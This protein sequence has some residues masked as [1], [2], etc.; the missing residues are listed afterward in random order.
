MNKQPNK[1]Y[2]GIGSRA[3]PLF[4][5]YQ[6]SLLSAI[7]EKKGYI[8]RSGCAAGADAAFEDSLELSNQLPEIY[9][10]NANFPKKVGGTN[11]P[12]YICPMDR[13]G[14]GSESLYREAMIM[15]DNHQ[16]HKA[17]KYCKSYAKDLHNRNI[18]QVLGQDLKT[19]SSFVVCY[20]PD[21]AK[22]YSDTNKG[23]GG[24]GT[25]I[26]TADK[27][28]VEVFNLSNP[29][30]Y[31]RI[32]KFIN[33]NLDLINL[34]RINNIKPRTILNS[35]NKTYEDLIDIIY[36]EERVFLMENK[37]PRSRPRL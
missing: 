4:I 15:I 19:P 9:I 12:H 32:K 3:A 37:K 28:S 20:T 29:E 6:M 23:T 24:T 34:K 36:E 30:D 26:N 16:L 17:W 18:F 27:N 31:R 11:K 33:D 2:T 14:K 13:Y 7:L 22:I 25:A 35:K 1:Y 21:G 8:L 10:P 5:L